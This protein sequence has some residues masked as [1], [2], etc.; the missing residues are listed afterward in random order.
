MERAE[1]G[2]RLTILWQ[3]VPRISRREGAS[4]L[5]RNPRRRPNPTRVQYIWRVETIAIDTPREFRGHVT[6]G[7]GRDLRVIW[8]RQRKVAE[9][10]SNADNRE[11]GEAY[12]KPFQ[13]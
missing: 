8:T 12:P 6:P 10:I 4:R 2:V 5:A 11:S 3:L 13:F 7:V 9:Q 1:A